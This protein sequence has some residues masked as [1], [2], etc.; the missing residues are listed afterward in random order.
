MKRAKARKGESAIRSWNIADLN[1]PFRT[2]TLACLVA[3]L[4]Y[5]AAKLGGTLVMR[6]QMVW[7]LWPC[8]VL[9]VSVLVLVRRRIWPIIIM[10]AFAAFVLLDLQ[11]GMP[12]RSIGLLI[13]SDVVEVLT[14]A[15]CLSYSFDG[16]PQLNSV[17]TLAK[18]SLFAV[19][20]APFAGAFIV[21]L[22][23]SGSYW[24]NWRISFLSEALGFLI[25]MPAILGM[26]GSIQA[27][28]AKPRTFYLEASVLI[29]ALTLFGYFTFTTTRN[30]TPPAL[31]YSLVPFL[32]WSALRFGSI[33]TS[34]SVIVVASFSIWGAVHGRGPFIELGPMKSVWSLQLFLFFTSA[35]FMVV[36]A[37]VEERKKT[38]E[39]LRE[40]QRVAH[41]GNWLLDQNSGAIKWSEEAYRIHGFDPKS[42]QPSYQ[43]I[44]QLFAPESWARLSAAFDKEFTSGSVQE[45]EL[46]LV[47]P[48]CGEKWV[49]AR[50]EPVRDASGR[51]THLRGTIQDISDRKR[52]EQAAQ[53][54]LTINHELELARQIQLS[55]LP[56]G[57]PKIEGLDIVA[58]YLPMSAVAG[59]FYDFIVVDEEH[60]G[61][62]IADV[63]GHG[64]PAALIA[65][66][67][68]VALTAQVA[69]AAE[70]GKVLSG[71]NRALCGKIRNQ[72]V[73]A[74]YVFVDMEENVISYSAAG[75][76][77]LLMWHS[78][79]R[80]ADE[81]IEN[82]LILGQFPDAVY[83]SL[84]LSVEAGDR[85]ALCTDGILEATNPFEEPFGTGRFMQFMENNYDL[86]ANQFADTLLDELSRWSGQTP[87]H[88][89]AD[90][91]TVLAIDFK[92]HG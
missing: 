90:D 88:G 29:A 52:A 76:P 45:L 91:I 78:S 3:I 89:Q 85:C 73:T 69:H 8:N 4:S 49:A 53:Q 56:G 63:S 84:Q 6:P 7:P 62:L 44:S 83:S 21:A 11:E 33:G 50:G 57:S 32:L 13:L 82:G 58:R 68:Q 30:S 5:L 36:A 51:I 77:P 2:V 31:L 23:S 48:D 59:D 60:V 80:T 1:S 54:L 17:K 15:L 81:V 9:V 27:W 34:V 64:L 42:P 41:V 66:M 20:L 43:E 47:S 86:G 92:S 14:A 22:S 16:V 55:I 46:E 10:A 61:I 35:P 72:F 38:Q 28:P 74:A 79:L 70:P 24:T 19:I 40:A 18:Y 26:V 25:L 75:H 71:L 65:S 87:G 67:L 39:E 37:L 12:I